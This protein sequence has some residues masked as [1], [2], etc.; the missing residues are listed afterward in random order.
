LRDDRDTSACIKKKKHPKRPPLP[1]LQ[2]FPQDV[3]VSS[4]LR[5][6]QRA[7]FPAFQLPPFWR[8]LQEHAGDHCDDEIRDAEVSECAQDTNALNE[9]RRHRR[10]D[11]RARSESPDRNAS[12]ESSSIGEP[13]YQHG[14]RNDI[15]K[16][17]T[18]AADQSVTDV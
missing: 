16:A 1:C 10:G 2:R 9:S 15:A 14:H 3:I 4:A 11:E 7:W 17:E 8:I 18:D 5:S 6:L 12:D 13:F